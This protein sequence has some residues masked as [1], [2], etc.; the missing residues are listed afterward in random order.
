MKVQHTLYS[1]KDYLAAVKEFTEINRMDIANAL[2]I[3]ALVNFPKCVA[4]NYY[5][6]FFEHKGGNTE[7]ALTY[8]NRVTQ[9]YNSNKIAKENLS[10]LNDIG[11]IFFF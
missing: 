10:Y 6:A 8:A 7:N 1:H 11:I 3:E 2:C 4:L 5:M 9:L